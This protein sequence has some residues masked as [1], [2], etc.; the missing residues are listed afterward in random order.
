MLSHA[1]RKV[2]F[3]RG[4]ELDL[5]R[6]AVLSD[7][8]V[9]VARELFQDDQGLRQALYEHK[10]QCLHAIIQREFAKLP[11]GALAK[12]RLR[13]ILMSY[14]YLAEEQPDFFLVH[15]AFESEAGENSS[16]CGMKDLLSRPIIALVVGGIAEI[17]AEAGIEAPEEHIVAL[18]LTVFSAV[19]GYNHLCAYS[20]SRHLVASAKKHTMNAILD[21]FSDGIDQYL[22][23]PE[24]DW[25]APVVPVE[26]AFVTP[27]AFDEI[28]ADT[29]ANKAYRLIRSGILRIRDE[30][31]G[32]VK[33]ELEAKRTGIPVSEAK[34]LFDG[35]YDFYDH[36]EKTLEDDLAVCISEQVAALPANATPL[37]ALKATGYGSLMWALRDPIGLLALSQ[38][39]SGSVV[40]S[41][42]AF[43]GNV[44]DSPIVIKAILAALQDDDP[45]VSPDNV[46]HT[47]VKIFTIWSAFHGIIHLTSVS[48]AAFLPE[49]TKFELANAV[50]DLA[51]CT[52][53]ERFGLDR[54]RIAPS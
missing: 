41:G 13:K 35:N 29:A 52:I 53:V 50:M 42:Q 51:I 2:V 19:H 39:M 23:D 27:P 5:D 10:E 8:D 25:L 21:A 14:F 22:V 12:D 28:P 38:V 46:W 32:A 3:E 43:Q 1:A 47:Y 48:S 45:A 7:I 16:A 4:T 24:V 11:P 20:N 49:S 18:G 6:I 9:D 44:D 15:L 30:N 37:N 26:T 31:L 54:E 36:I 33:L 17:I 34:A 40:P